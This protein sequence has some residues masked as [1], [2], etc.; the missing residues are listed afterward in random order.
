WPSRAD[1]ARRQQS[2][3]EIA[4]RHLERQAGPVP[5]EL[6]WKTRRLLGTLGHR[7][8]S[9]VEF[10]SMRSTEEDGARAIQAI[11]LQPARTGW[12]LHDREG[13]KRNGRAAG[14]GCLGH[15]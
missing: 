9:G 10:A 14:F 3:S 1:F 11:H 15:P 13:G 4:V 12:P 7:C 2:A 6:A 5:S 8:R